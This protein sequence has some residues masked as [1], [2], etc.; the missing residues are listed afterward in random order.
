MSA[1]GRAGRD[2]ISVDGI[3]TSGWLLALAK[4]VGRVFKRYSHMNAVPIL[5][6]VLEQVRQNNF[7]DLRVLREMVSNMA[8]VCCR[9]QFQRRTGSSHGWRRRATGP[10]SHSTSRY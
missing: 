2:R 8:G 7:T 1:L 6:Y 5:Q 4:L 3:S 9:H 10:N